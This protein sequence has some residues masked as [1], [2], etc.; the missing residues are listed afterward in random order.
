MKEKSIHSFIHSIEAKE[1]TACAASGRI[2]TFLL[3]LSS[4][5]PPQWCN[6]YA[7]HTLSP[8]SDLFLSNKP[9]FPM[10]LDFSIP[11]G[12]S[13]SFM[14]T[15]CCLYIEQVCVFWA[16]ASLTAISAGANTVLSCG[17]CALTPSCPFYF[18][19]FSTKTIGSLHWWHS[20]E[21]QGPYNVQELF[22]RAL[23]EG[24]SFD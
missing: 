21:G 10:W 8:E 7:V 18:G 24:L 11:R 9:R 22:G 16:F 1:T 13:S 4:K 2:N 3:Y 19:Q 15:D 23:D 17:A 6:Q 20:R 12:D 14:D 5:W